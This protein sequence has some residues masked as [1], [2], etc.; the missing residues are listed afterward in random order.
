[1]GVEVVR[2]LTHD[3]VD[4]EPVGPEALGANPLELVEHVG[5]LIFGRLG[6]VLLPHDHRHIT[7]LAIGDPAHVVLVVPRRDARRLAELA[8][9]VSEHG[10]GYAPE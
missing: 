3:G 10:A 7:D 2:D 4:V 9:I 5:P 8:L 6:A 1:M